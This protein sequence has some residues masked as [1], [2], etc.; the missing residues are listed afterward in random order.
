MLLE[1]GRES[2]LLAACRRQVEIRRFVPDLQHEKSLVGRKDVL[3]GAG[4]A[5]DVIAARHRTAK[6]L[7]HLVPQAAGTRRVVA[8]DGNDVLWYL[9]EH[10][11]CIWSRLD[12][13]PR[14]GGDRLF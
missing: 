14:R 12:T 5:G 9:H 1:R 3:E 13:I 11:A 8:S 4:E 7:A 2:E 6:G 10:L